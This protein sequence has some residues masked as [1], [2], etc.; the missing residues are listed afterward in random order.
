MRRP[1]TSLGHQG[2]RR[3]FWEG[4][5]LFKL[6]RIVLNYP[7]RIFP[8]GR[9]IFQGRFAPLVAG[10]FVR[11]DCSLF[12]L[13]KRKIKCFYTLKTKIGLEFSTTKGGESIVSLL[14][15]LRTGRKIHFTKYTQT[16][17]F[18]RL[19]KI[20]VA[21]SWRFRRFFALAS[22]WTA[23]RQSRSIRCW[24]VQYSNFSNIR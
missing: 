12:R 17:Y 1:V 2:W 4:P 24:S 22:T 11:L 5:E 3:V 13:W 20:T 9:K 16:K 19:K 7:Q 15:S 18:K 14:W 23:S 8:G 10:L 21:V 6:C